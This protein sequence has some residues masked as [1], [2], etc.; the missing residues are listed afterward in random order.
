MNEPTTAT[1]PE[2]DAPR[3][4]TP[5]AE[6][7]HPEA[8]AWAER[9]DPDRGPEEG[10]N[11]D[12]WPA[13]H[14]VDLTVLIPVKNEQVNMERCLRHLHWCKH[15]YVI[16]SQSHDATIPM[17]QAMGAEVYQFYYKGGW[18]KKRNWALDTLHWPTEWVLILDADEVMTPELAREIRDVVEGHW[19]PDK[20]E[21]A[22]CGDG[23]WLN[24]RFMFM[25]SWIKHCGY[26]PSYN[27]RLFK[28][29]AGRYERIGQLGDTGS[30]DN[31]VHEHVVLKTGDAGYLK[32]EFLHYAY[33]NLAVWTEK[34][35]RYTTWEAYA[36][37][38][39]NKGQIEAKLRGGAIQR[40]RW[41]KK[42]ARKLPFRPTLRFLY[43]YVYQRGFLDGYPGYIMCRLMAWYELMSIAKAR[44]MKRTGQVPDDIK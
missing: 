10:D 21:N 17:S 35:N 39:G 22:G 14:S 28:H 38:A 37:L 44:E 41:I 26:Y 24:R 42:M 43:G 2:H 1:Q 8:N 30:G 36:M 13:R 15:I 25:G 3:A 12:V 27:I 29:W 34:H 19:T 23:Y 6:P 18:P 11:P 20:P 33:P 32:H 4:D 40:R 31:E 5:T 7:R 9:L 16:D